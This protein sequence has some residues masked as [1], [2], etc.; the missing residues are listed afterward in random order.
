MVK[1]TYLRGPI[2]VLTIER[3]AADSQVH[4]EANGAEE[5]QWRD[6]GC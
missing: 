3:A 5:V 6:A 2:V 4:P 1:A